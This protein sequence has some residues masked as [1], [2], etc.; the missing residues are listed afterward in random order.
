MNAVWDR[1][2]FIRHSD[3]PESLVNLALFFSGLLVV[4][5]SR[6]RYQEQVI[7]SLF[8]S[9]GR[10]KVRLEDL[11]ERK[12]A[13]I[14]CLTDLER[15]LPLLFRNDYCLHLV[16]DKA[17]GQHACR[18]S[19]QGKMDLARVVTGS[20]A[21]PGAFTPSPLKLDDGCGAGLSNW[22]IVSDGGVYNNLA[23][24]WFLQD[25]GLSEVIWP[26]EAGV[27]R[28]VAD[29]IFVVDASAPHRFQRLPLHDEDVSIW[30]EFKGLLRVVGVI[31]SSNVAHRQMVLDIVDDTAE[32]PSAV[33]RLAVG[34][35]VTDTVQRHRKSGCADIRNR[36]DQ[37]LADLLEVHHQEEWDRLA[38]ISGSMKTGLG[39]VK[40]PVAQSLLIHGYYSMAAALHI[41]LGRSAQL[42][43]LRFLDGDNRVLSPLRDEPGPSGGDA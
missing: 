20:A 21:F 10:G 22:T 32:T 4:L 18:V 5:S 34:T 19:S 7:S 29:H 6:N 2:P 35:P 3:V 23:T 38:V 36:A 1:I 12:V 14:F 42:P 39:K 16:A 26:I 24:N 31:N 25:F 30:G 33:H 9:A 37:V 11:A 41:H 17:T 43:R 40:A 13:H 27:S 28:D 8:R 15:G